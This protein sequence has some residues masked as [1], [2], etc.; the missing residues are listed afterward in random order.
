MQEQK[1]G[2]QKIVL[3]AVYVSMHLSVI[4]IGLVIVTTLLP[5]GVI[6]F[7]KDNVY[8]MCDLC[9]LYNCLLV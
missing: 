8:R 5:C 1:F 2:R 4:Y 9:V 6:D 7:Q 3:G